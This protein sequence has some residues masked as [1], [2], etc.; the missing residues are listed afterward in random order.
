MGIK[1]VKLGT[2]L[3]V[4]TADIVT[5]YI[6]A[7]QGYGKPFQ[8]VTDWARTAYCVGGYVANYTGM[9]GEDNPVTESAVLSS[10]P[11]LEKS[12]Y[13]GIRRYAKLGRMGLKM[14]RPGRKRPTRGNVRWG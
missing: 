3:G 11:L 4:G 7:K 13:K 8:N 5:E 1:L 12:I 9:G 6:D 2:S 14:K 10:L